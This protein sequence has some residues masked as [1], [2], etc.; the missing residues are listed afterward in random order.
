[1]SDTK[2]TP[3]PLYGPETP[4]YAILNNALAP[5]TAAI[6]PRRAPQKKAGNVSPDHKPK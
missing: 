6:K 1:M 3:Q 2:H 5:Q 4:G